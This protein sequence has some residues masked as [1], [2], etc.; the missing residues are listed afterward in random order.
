MGRVQYLNSKVF[1]RSIITACRYKMI[2]KIF[3]TVFLCLKN[4]R[5]LY[6]KLCWFFKNYRT[7]NIEKNNGFNNRYNSF[8]VYIEY[9]SPRKTK[10]TTLKVQQHSIS[11]Q[12]LTHPLLQ[13]YPVV[14]KLLAKIESWQA[15]CI[16]ARL[17][18]NLAPPKKTRLKAK[19]FSR[20]K[21]GTGRS[22]DSRVAGPSEPGE[23]GSPPPHFSKRPWIVYFLSPSPRLSDLPPV[24]QQTMKICL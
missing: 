16:V 19:A 9:L 2:C 15:N 11:R 7:W 17:G 18:E 10:K 24:L 6:L 20:A 21:S 8:Q 22:V 4:L 14:K 5:Q 3:P 1:N 12:I 13:H 23:Q